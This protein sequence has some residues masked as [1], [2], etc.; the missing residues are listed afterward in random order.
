MLIFIEFSW[1][2]DRRLFSIVLSASLQW[3]RFAVFRYP[4]LV[5]S[6][7]FCERWTVNR[8]AWTHCSLVNVSLGFRDLVYCCRGNRIE[9]ILNKF[10]LDFFLNSDRFWISTRIIWELILAYCRSRF[11]GFESDCR[12]VGQFVHCV[13][14]LDCPFMGPSYD[15]CSCLC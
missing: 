7:T 3:A 2:V 10:L 8:L 14:P 6:F 13:G 1:I 15:R 4:G 11:V 12:T 5:H 9:F